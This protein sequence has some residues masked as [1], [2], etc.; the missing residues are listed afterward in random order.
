MILSGMAEIKQELHLNYVVLIFLVQLETRIVVCAE[1][2]FL[3]SGQKNKL[4]YR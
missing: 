2:L 4:A 3:E 1:T